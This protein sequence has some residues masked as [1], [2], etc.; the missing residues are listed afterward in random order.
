MEDLVP[1]ENISYDETGLVHFIIRES[2]TDFNIDS[3]LDIPDT[4]FL[5]HLSN[6]FAILTIGPGGLIIPPESGDAEMNIPNAQIKELISKSGSLEYTLKNFVD[7]PL[8][9]TYSLPKATQNGEFILIE[10]PM[11]PG[12]YEN[13][14]IVQNSYD[15]SDYH[16]DLTGVNGDSFNQ[17]LNEISL[18]VDPDSPSNVVIPVQDTIIKTEVSFVNP[19]VSYARGYFGQHE[20]DFDDVTNLEQLN[21]IVSGNLDIDGIEVKLLIE[22]YAG[23]DAQV[24]LNELTGKNT[25]TGVEISLNHS[26]IQNSINIT[27]ATDYGSYVEPTSIR[28]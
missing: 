24:V 25:D 2:L 9:A 7:G 10:E 8:L 6:S 17:M 20:F 11:P 12:S 16:F 19:K 22:N 23:I 5:D 28:L 27:R 13:P 4:T 1:S 26:D 18:F 14:S 21:N 15:L 3:L